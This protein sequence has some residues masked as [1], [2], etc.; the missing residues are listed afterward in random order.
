MSI[1]K[2]LKDHAL[3]IAFGDIVPKGL[4]EFSEYFRENKVINF[5]N[6]KSDGCLIAKSTNFKW[7][8]IITEGK[9]EKE[10]DENVKDAILTAFEV[11]SSYIKESGL[12]KIG[13]LKD[14]REYAIAK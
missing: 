9:D 4:Y 3:K 13:A 2:Q 10:L 14:R 5:Q 11:P 1:F 6:I 8:T 12:R 7:G